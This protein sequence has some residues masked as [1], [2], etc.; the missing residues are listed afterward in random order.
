MG[1][2]TLGV[3]ENR[4]SI[5]ERDILMYLRPTRALLTQH[6][7]PLPQRL[8]LRST[9]PASSPR[10]LPHRVRLSL[11]L[12]P[13]STLAEPAQILNNLP[14]RTRTDA[15]TPRPTNPTRD[16]WDGGRYVRVR[17]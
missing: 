4:P 11:S 8:C 2:Y 12:P 3:T 13:I 7:L 17:R 5:R 9:L 16:Q 10:L 14:H 1:E 15:R 6:N